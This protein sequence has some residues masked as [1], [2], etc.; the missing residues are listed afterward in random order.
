M[1]HY[2][3]NENNK[4]IIGTNNT[5]RLAIDNDGNIGIGTTNPSYKL[6]INGTFNY[7]NSYIRKISNSATSIS[8]ATHTPINYQTTVTNYGN[9]MTITNNARVTI[10]TKG[11][12]YVI[13]YHRWGTSSSGIRLTYIAHHDINDNVIQWAGIVRDQDNTT[14][15][16]A[17]TTHSI[18]NCNE[19]D[20][21][22]IRVY[23]DSGTSINANNIS[24]LNDFT[25][26]RLGNSY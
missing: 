20:Y 24:S 9:D 4:I 10:N 15:Q 25:I 11:L 2:I 21:I 18:L 7:K 26:Y 12:Y 19:N 3:K 5:D 8:T 14:N 22:E 17:Q 23:Q 16:Y 6:D 13:A 1:T